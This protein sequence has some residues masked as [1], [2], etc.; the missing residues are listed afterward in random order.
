MIILIVPL[1]CLPTTVDVSLAYPA[2]I[3]NIN[4][5]LHQALSHKLT[6]NTIGFTNIGSGGIITR[7]YLAKWESILFDLRP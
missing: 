1:I 6:F 5:N 3:P 7:L 4:S 2:Y